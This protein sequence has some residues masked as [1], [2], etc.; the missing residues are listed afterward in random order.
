MAFVAARLAE[1]SS[2]GTGS[3]RTVYAA[4]PSAGDGFGCK[5]G[6]G[7]VPASA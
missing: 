2:A 7:T 3:L 5:S 1:Q 6:S 4:G